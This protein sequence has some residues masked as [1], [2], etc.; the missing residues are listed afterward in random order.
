MCDVLPVIVPNLCLLCLFALTAGNRRNVDKGCRHHRCIGFNTEVEPGGTGIVDNLEEQGVI[1]RFEL[2]LQPLLV[3]RCI[4]LDVFGENLRVVQP[5]LQC[6]VAAD[7]QECLLLRDR[8][9]IPMQIGCTVFADD[10]VMHLRVN[11][12]RLLFPLQGFVADGKRIAGFDRFCFRFV[13]LIEGDVAV[14][15]GEG[16]NGMPI[17]KRDFGADWVNRRCIGNGEPEPAELLVPQ[18]IFVFEANLQ[19][20]SIIS[21]ILPKRRGDEEDCLPIFASSIQGPSRFR[22]IV[23]CIRD[24]EV[25]AC[26]LVVCPRMHYGE[27]CPRCSIGFCVSISISISGDFEREIGEDDVAIVASANTAFRQ[28]FVRDA[29]QPDGTPFAG[30]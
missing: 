8:I 26:L 1:T 19:G 16:P 30:R 9:D 20:A 13:S 4:A 18:V 17:S 7:V 10:V 25:A 28:R 21:K 11:P 2:H 5:D 12:V 23:N 22:F 29:F 14:C 3:C 27:R 6:I 24:D 15:C